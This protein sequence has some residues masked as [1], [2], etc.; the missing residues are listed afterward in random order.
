MGGR[1][2]ITFS[3]RTAEQGEEIELCAS[4]LRYNHKRKCYQNQLHAWLYNLFRFGF[5]VLI[6]VKTL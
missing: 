3:A 4:W 2:R 6:S 5:D 1:C